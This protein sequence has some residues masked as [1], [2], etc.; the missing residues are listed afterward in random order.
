[1]AM[2]TVTIMLLMAMITTTLPTACSCVYPPI[3]EA[4][5]RKT[6]RT[7]VTLCL[8]RRVEPEQTLHTF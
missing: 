6:S 1:M 2:M 5:G 8:A 4:R 7:D 3:E